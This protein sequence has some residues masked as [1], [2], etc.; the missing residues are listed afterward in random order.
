MVH[1]LWII[2][3]VL[4]IGFLS[5]PRFR[6]DIA[7][8]R[9]RRILT[10][11]LEK[12]RYTVL[13]DIT[14]PSGGGT[15]HFD[16]IVVSRFGVFVIESQYAVGWVSGGP[17]QDRWKQYRW[18]R[19][20]LFDNPV[21]RNMLQVEALSRALQIPGKMIHPVVVMAGQKGFRS[22][23]PEKVVE[24]EK[25]IGYMRKK[26]QPLLDEQ[27]PGRV[28]KAIESA[29]LQPSVLTTT[30][31]W[32]LLQLALILVLLLGA[33]F[34]FHDE[35]SQLQT[36]IRESQEQREAPERFH[37]DGSRKTEQEVWED[38]LVCAYSE[39]TGRC[40]CYEPNGSKVDL[41]PDKCRSL[42]E[43]GSVL[44]Q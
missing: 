31:K 44:K 8:T 2:P 17:S 6:G 4:L 33:Y 28:L 19:F 27:Q 1:A 23:M 24:P 29:R 20:T 41:E 13:N 22:A 38:S 9:V 42:A 40:A 14:I 21:H 16:H 25:L 36:S 18:G 5:S 43:R 7:E 30:G 39:D 26:A 32:R 3:L 11:G 15:V 37:P 10:A 12:S 35:I 34:A